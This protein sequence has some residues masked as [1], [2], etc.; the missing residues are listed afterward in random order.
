M[1]REWVRHANG[2]PHGDH[3]RALIF[4]RDDF[5]AGP[6][7]E[8]LET[9]LRKE[10]TRLDGEALKYQETER[11]KDVFNKGYRQLQEIK[12]Q[13]ADSPNFDRADAFDR[14]QSLWR[15]LK[16]KKTKAKDWKSPQGADAA[17]FLAEVTELRDAVQTAINRP[18]R[19]DQQAR[20]LAGRG[21]E[22]DGK[23]PS[24]H[25]TGQ[26]GSDEGVQGVSADL[27]LELEPEPAPPSRTLL[28]VVRDA[29][30]LVSSSVGRTVTA[31]DD[32]LSDVLGQT[33]DEYESVLIAVENRLTSDLSA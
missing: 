21:T 32:A 12:R 7:F 13:I 6:A 33:S 14:L 28:A 19:G 17:Q 24:S 8:Y 29:G 27:E 23:E 16:N 1:R 5:E 9:E 31:I 18:S 26:L 22:G 15:D 3:G 4:E 25:S 2:H 11:A 30:W 20:D 10:M